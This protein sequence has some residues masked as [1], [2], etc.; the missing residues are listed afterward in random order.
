MNILKYITLL[1]PFSNC[2]E[3]DIHK[4]PKKLLPYVPEKVSIA[5]HNFNP[6]KYFDIFTTLTS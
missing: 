1:L 3:I 5:L 2:L 4:R 6:H